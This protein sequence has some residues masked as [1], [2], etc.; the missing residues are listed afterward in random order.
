MTK[1]RRII[2]TTATGE[3]ETPGRKV[4]H[5]STVMGK[6]THLREG[7]TGHLPYQ[8]LLPGSLGYLTYHLAEKLYCYHD[9][10]ARSVAK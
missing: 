6:Q 4:I 1:Y 7:S 9:E 5:W 10:V 2:D 3:N 8:R